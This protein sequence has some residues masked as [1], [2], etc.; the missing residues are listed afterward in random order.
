MS[1]TQMSTTVPD[2]LILLGQSQGVPAQPKLTSSPLLAALKK[3]G[4]EHIYADTASQEELGEVLRVDQGTILEEIDGNTVNQ[5]LMAKVI[6]GYLERDDPAEWVQ[7]L[8][9]QGQECS[10]KEILPLLYSI[11][12]GSLGADMV[13]VFARGRSWEVSLQL[14]M[15]LLNNY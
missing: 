5:P 15:G 11:V 9:E 3:V 1:I 10:Q 14:H 4:T 6:K 2:A 13:R 7:Q 12:C 8:H